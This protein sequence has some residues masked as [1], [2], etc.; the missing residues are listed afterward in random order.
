MFRLI[1]GCMQATIN[2]FHNNP[3]KGNGLPFNF[4]FFF[5]FAS[6]GQYFT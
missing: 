1:Y 5:F 2:L 3:I 4:P 6:V